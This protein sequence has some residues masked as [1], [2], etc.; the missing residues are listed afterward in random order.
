MT[1]SKDEAQ[2]LALVKYPSLSE[3]H[4]RQ[5]NPPFDFDV[6]GEMDATELAS[7]A[8]DRFNIAPM[9]YTIE[10]DGC[11]TYIQG[12]HDTGVPEILAVDLSAEVDPL[13]KLL[14]STIDEHRAHP[15]PGDPQGNCYIV[16]DPC[17]DDHGRAT[18]PPWSPHGPMMQNVVLAV[19]AGRTHEVR[20]L[21]GGFTKDA[22]AKIIVNEEISTFCSIR[23]SARCTPNDPRE[24]FT[25]AYG[26]YLVFFRACAF[27]Y[28]DFIAENYDY[29][30]IDPEEYGEPEYRDCDIPDY[31]GEAIA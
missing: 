5:V 13:R 2:R 4:I 7:E 3:T 21:R 28:F 29:D 30:S 25:M 6:F 16:I 18:L 23:Q 31:P 14:E 26:N 11:V 1:L 19:I 9:L 8:S 12:Q 24:I 17:L 20:P 22:L 15:S 10:D 27:C